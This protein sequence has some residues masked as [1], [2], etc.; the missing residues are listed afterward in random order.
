MGVACCGG[1]EGDERVGEVSFDVVE[2]WVG[3]GFWRERLLL[4]FW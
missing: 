2:V 1:D 4:L 3:D